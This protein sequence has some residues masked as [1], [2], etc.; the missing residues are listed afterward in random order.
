MKA[1]LNTL[2]TKP[3]V[4]SQIR[5]A[6]HLRLF[7]QSGIARRHNV[8]DLK[9][10]TL[11]KNK[12]YIN[13]QWVDAGSGKT[14]EVHDPSTGNVI[15]TMPEMNKS[16]V[17]EAIKAASQAFA[18]FKKTTGRERAKMLRKWCV[19]HPSAVDRLYHVFG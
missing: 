6:N 10:K 15:G 16:D 9:D 3:T 14:F 13:G 12:S 7:S 5:P 11:L 1:F 19:L 17:N 2:A 18:S 8:P 4:R